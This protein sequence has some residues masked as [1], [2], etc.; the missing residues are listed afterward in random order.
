MNETHAALAPGTLRTLADGVRALLLDEQGRG[1]ADVADARP[2]EVAEHARTVVERE[3]RRRAAGDERALPDSEQVV[4]QLVAHVSGLGV[5]QAPLDDDEIEDLGC[6]SPGRLWE[7]RAS[8]RTLSQVTL[9]DDEEAEQLVR[10]LLRGEREFSEARPF[11]DV[12]RNGLRLNA[13]RPPITKHVVFMIRKDVHRGAVWDD[14]EGLGFLVPRPP[15]PVSSLSA[16]AL[17]RPEG[18]LR[19]AVRRGRTIIVAGSPGAGKTRF[20]NMLGTVIPERERVLTIEDDRELHLDEL[21]A[22]CVSMQTRERNSEGEGE[23]SMR[24]LVINALRQRPHRILIGEVRGAEAYD[25]MIAIATGRGGMCTIH[26]E[27]VPHAVRRLKETMRMHPEAMAQPERSISSTIAGAVD[28]IVLVHEEPTL[29]RRTVESIY[30]LTGVDGDEV[31]G[32]ELFARVRRGSE[33]VLEA[34]GAA[35]QRVGRRT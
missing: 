10:R 14:M 8:G 7:Y 9:Q 28:L 31:T 11:V 20:L 4:R 32:Q 12:T 19:D 15:L 2:E 25:L 35:P 16:E 6:N 29:L 17:A 27:D 26:A 23:V 1:Y 33:Y 3:G 18:F 13:M 24:D 21:L 5:I 34:T 22:D 30:E